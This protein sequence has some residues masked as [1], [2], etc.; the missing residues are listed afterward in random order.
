VKRILFVDDDRPV[1]D[2]L[3]DVLRP[4]RRE[5]EMV[6]V[7]S[8]AAALSALAAEPCDVVV[9][10]LR[11]PGMDGA[12]LLA[13]V[14]ARHPD[15]IRIVMSGQADVDTVARAAAVAHRLIAKP[16][17]T[18]EIVRIIERS[19]ALHDVA[20]RVERRRLAVGASEL[21]CAPRVYLEL[22]RLLADPNAGAADAAEL[23]AQDIALSAKL[24]Q[25]ANSGFVGRGNAIVNVRQAVALVGLNTL[26]ALAV[27]VGAHAQF[28]D[29]GRAVA[30]FSVDEL[31]RRASQVARVAAIVRG[32]E[33][34][35]DD[36][37][38]AA[39]LLDIGLLVLAQQE[40]DHLRELMAAAGTDARTL[41]EVERDRGDVSH[42]EIGAHLLAV[43]GL[44]HSIVEVVAHHADP[45]AIPSPVFDVAA[46]TFIA[47]AIVDTLH[48][49]AM[50]GSGGLSALDGDYL[51]ALGV[52]SRLDEWIE[53]AGN[54]LSTA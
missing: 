4:R 49:H 51:D 36:A 39:L 20:A 9:S 37:F 48:P 10:D 25:L 54:E 5:W 18:A 45:T 23:V 2:G 15:T 7:D 52:R 50:F 26:R 33:S 3:R 1:L 19:S 27:S 53:V 34:D 44:P 47:L 31:Q 13:E 35:A 28:G 22:T 21:P 40:P 42:A 24:L 8:G 17:E 43:W 46:A 30:G 38:S 12:T 41:T 32:R 6:F 14:A 16:C 11:M 29:G